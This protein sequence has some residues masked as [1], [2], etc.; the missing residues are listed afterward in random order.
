MN[1]DIIHKS[2]S[3]GLKQI[4]LLKL[5]CISFMLFL[6]SCARKSNKQN[7][8]ILTKAV[9]QHIKNQDIPIPVGFFPS[10]KQFCD[11]NNNISLCYKGNLSVNKSLDFLKKSMELSGW[12]IKHFSLKNEGLL[13]CNKAK[14]H[15]AISI[16][17]IPKK[18][19]SNK[20]KIYVMLQED[21]AT[22][23]KNVHTADMNPY[24]NNQGTSLDT[25]KNSFLDNINTKEVN[26]T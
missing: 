18:L 11:S 3:S 26:I 1:D 8:P 2:F 12:D 15:C 6:C 25:I 16:R 4:N 14:K 5:I 13:F 20:T 22:T 9:L 7:T 19:S 24:Q 21:K 23:S 17:S 10:T